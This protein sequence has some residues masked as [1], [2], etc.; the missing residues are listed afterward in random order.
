MDISQAKKYIDDLQKRDLLFHFDDGAIDCLYRNDL[1]DL[2]SAI[3]IDKTIIDQAKEN[4]RYQYYSK[5]L[6]CLYDLFPLEG[7]KMF[8]HQFGLIL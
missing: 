6:S 1:C 4:L 3:E 7:A 8:V 2:E 5:P